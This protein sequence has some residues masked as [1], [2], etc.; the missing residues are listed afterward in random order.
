MSLWLES[1]AVALLA[2]IPSGLLIVRI[3]IEEQVLRQ[4]LTGYDAYTRKVSADSL[5]VVSQRRLT[6]GY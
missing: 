6:I 2:I 5:T 4:D 3:L 1:Y